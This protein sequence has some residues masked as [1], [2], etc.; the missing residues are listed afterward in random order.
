MCKQLNFCFEIYYFDERDY[1]FDV[2]LPDYLDV[3]VM[4]GKS[5]I[6]DVSLFIGSLLSFNELSLDLN[7]IEA[8]NKKE[9][10]LV[11]GLE[12]LKDDIRIGP[13]CCADIQGCSNVICGI[14]N[15][16]T[17]WMGHD[18]SPWFEFYNDE[19][20]LWN[21]AI[22]SENLR[23]IKLSQDEFESQLVCAKNGL[24]MFL[25][26]VEDWA[27]VNYKQNPTE[28]ILAVKKFLRD[29]CE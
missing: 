13:S 27:Q 1:D 15:R 11:G 23:S 28:L 19:I 25:M 24:S 10:A 5:N 20:T 18:P 8:L 12:F 16:E 29:S 2:V 22:G 4:G 21:D 3:V 9:L 7:F 14:R 6:N 26:Q 17:A